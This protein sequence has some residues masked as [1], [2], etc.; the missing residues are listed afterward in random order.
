[1]MGL[2][3]STDQGFLANLPVA[4][5]TSISTLSNPSASAWV[6]QLSFRT[7]K[8]GIEHILIGYDH[9]FIVNKLKNKMIPSN[10][11]KIIKI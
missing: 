9:L 7:L 11:F 5:M 4:E 10:F 1:M 2:P 8:L 3:I 6:L